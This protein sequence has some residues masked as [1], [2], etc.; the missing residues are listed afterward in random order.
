MGKQ[1]FRV[2]LPAAR[3]IL[4]TK[5]GAIWILS[6]LPQASILLAV[7]EAAG[8]PWDSPWHQL[9]LSA[10]PLTPG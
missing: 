5:K 6:P 9:G 10:L 8:Y 7:T 2:V 3:S 1:P 4:G